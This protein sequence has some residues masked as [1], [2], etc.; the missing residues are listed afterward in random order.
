ML[1]GHQ[2]C[3]RA[4]KPASLGARKIIFVLHATEIV[5]PLFAAVNK[6]NIHLIAQIQPDVRII[7]GLPKLMEFVS[8]RSPLETMRDLDAPLGSMRRLVLKMY[9]E[10]SDASPIDIQFIPSLSFVINFSIGRGEPP[11]AI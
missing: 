11:R 8:S 1:W 4:E 6:L 10:L 7:Y 2:Y 3:A 9:F 5:Q